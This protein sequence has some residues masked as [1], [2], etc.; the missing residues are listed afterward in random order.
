MTQDQIINIGLAIISG[1]C[2][3][4][5]FLYKEVKSLRNEMHKTSIAMVKLSV[6]LRHATRASRLFPKMS[7]DVDAAHQ[8]IR[9]IKAQLNS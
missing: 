3:F 8:E 2:L 9:S 5:G 7:K 4:F 1:M 6:E